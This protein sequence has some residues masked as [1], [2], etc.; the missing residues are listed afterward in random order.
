MKSVKTWYWITTLLF[1][2]FMIFSAVPNVMNTKEAV[3][4]ISGQLGYPAYF[5]PFI[6]VAKITGCIA[7]LI[8]SF[9]RI[10]EWAY[11]G[12]F[13]DLAGAMYSAFAKEGFQPMILT[14]ML[15][16]AFLFASYFLWHKLTDQK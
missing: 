1:A 9:R 7:I 16:V 11:A 5:V 12:L 4:M 10:K 2:A 6:G 8:P 15:P 14:L 13:F 3:D